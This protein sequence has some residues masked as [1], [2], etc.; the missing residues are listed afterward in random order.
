MGNGTFSLQYRHPPQEV[1][2][3]GTALQGQQGQQGQAA[4]FSLQ[5]LT[6]LA[7]CCVGER[8]ES[9]GGLKGWWKLCGIGNRGVRSLGAIR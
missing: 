2:S 5:L 8:G 3:R 1:L 4:G 7:M 9:G 6:V